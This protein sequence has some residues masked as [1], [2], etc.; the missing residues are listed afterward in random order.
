MILRRLF[1]LILVLGFTFPC[2]AQ[3]DVAGTDK[4]FTADV[5]KVTLIAKTADEKKFCDYVIQKRDDGTIPSRIIYG[6]YRQAITKDRNRRFTYFKTGL[7]IV[8]KREGILLNTITPVKTSPTAPSL[9]PP[10]LK[11]LF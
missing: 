10:A 2:F 7:E 1:F 5:L 3:K 9:I 11:S 4:L 6:V 8:C